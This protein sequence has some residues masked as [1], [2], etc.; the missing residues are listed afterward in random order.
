MADFNLDTTGKLDDVRSRMVLHL[1]SKKTGTVTNIETE[2]PKTDDT[3]TENEHS[4]I[5]GTVGKW[6][7]HFDG[8]KDT[9]EFLERLYDLKSCYR[10]RDDALLKALPDVFR[11]KAI[12]WFRNNV[13]SWENWNNFTED[14]NL[15]FKS[16]NWLDDLEDQ[17]R[18]RTKKTNERFKD[19]LLELQMLIR[20]QGNKDDELTKKNENRETTKTKKEI[21]K[22]E[23]DYRQVKK[24]DE[25]TKKHENRE[26]RPQDGR[27]EEEEQRRF[28][29]EMLEWH[30]RQP[31]TNRSGTPKH[32]T[33]VGDDM[34]KEINKEK[35]D[36]GENDSSV[37]IT[38][39]EET[40]AERE[41]E[42]QRNA[43]WQDT[44]ESVLS[45]LLFDEADKE[46]IKQNKKRKGDSLEIN[47]KFKKEKR[48]ESLTYSEETEN[49]RIQRKLKEVLEILNAKG[50]IEGEKRAKARKL[51]GEI[52]TIQN[53]TSQ[54]QNQTTQREEEDTKCE[55]CK[56]K[57]KQ[58][59]QKKETEK[60]IRVLNGG[61]NINHFSQICKKGWEEKV[62]EKTKW[63]QGGLQDTIEKKECLIVTNNDIKEGGVESAIRTIREDVYEIIEGCKEGSIE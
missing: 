54:T 22:Q 6:G 26:E 17:I 24:D 44:E 3:Q 59:R 28:E 15:A 50:S 52:T 29:Q 47:E 5:M 41:K 8:S 14:F 27:S 51:I 34:V 36:T 63:E 56:I 2:D 9:T 60:I 20:R 11:G 42:G 53:R 38:E 43:Q 12:L 21:G 33:L 48:E 45:A 58:E 30:N 1:R 13:D 37:Q 39:E 55:Q 18:T 19:F 62:Y 40:E 7:L 35:E 23:D 4:Q 61:R 25:L 57:I 31:N 49:E 46:E 32:S 16:T 10:I